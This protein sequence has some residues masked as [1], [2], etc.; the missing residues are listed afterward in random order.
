MFLKKKCDHT[1]KT[2]AS[3]TETIK[4]RAW[5]HILFQC[6]RCGEW[7]VDTVPGRW[8]REEISELK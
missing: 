6:S 3:Q 7:Y 8:T 2:L 1:Y 5:T 4:D